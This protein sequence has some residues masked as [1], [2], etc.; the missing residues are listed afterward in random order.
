VQRKKQGENYSETITGTL[1]SSTTYFYPGAGI[2]LSKKIAGRL[3]GSVGAAYSFGRSGYA[4]G[5]QKT[6]Y[7]GNASPGMERYT[8]PVSALQFKAGLA[9][10]VPHHHWWPC[11]CCKSMS[12]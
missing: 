9:L 1:A 6:D 8:Q 4:I 7:L 10:L 3:Y 2:R 5:Y 11:H 12:K